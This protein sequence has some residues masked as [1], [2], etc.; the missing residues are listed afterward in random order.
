MTA[1]A[2]QLPLR[3]RLIRPAEVARCEESRD[4]LQCGHELGHRA[5][6]RALEDGRLRV[7]W[8][9]VVWAGGGR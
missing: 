9:D 5:E 1:P 7:W 4:G 8:G 2:K 3:L 6:H